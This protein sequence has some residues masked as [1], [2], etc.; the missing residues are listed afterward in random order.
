MRVLGASVARIDLKNDD[1]SIFLI[2]EVFTAPLTN[3]HWFNWKK[4][5]GNAAFWKEYTFNSTTTRVEIRD[6]DGPTVV[7]SH[8]PAP[9]M[10]GPTYWA[11][12][13]D[14]PRYKLWNESYS[15]NYPNGLV[16]VGTTTTIQELNIG[17]TNNVNDVASRFFNGYIAEVI[18]YKCAM[19]DSEVQMV[20]DYIRTKYG[21]P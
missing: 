15:K 5:G 1:I 10:T 8:G 3:G 11:F 9:L 14:H 20:F 21:L 19:T 18:V 17:G 12:V 13:K 2:G 7:D 6:D 16:N 4:T